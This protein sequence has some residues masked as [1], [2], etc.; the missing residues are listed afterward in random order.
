MQGHLVGAEALLR[1]R[2]PENGM[3]SPLDFIPLAEQLGL[4]DR[5]QDI[6]LRESCKF[7]KTLQ[8]ANSVDAGFSV[9][10]NISAIQFRSPNFESGIVETVAEFDLKPEHIK[11]EITES[12]LIDNVDQTIK[13]MQRLNEKGFRFSIDDFGT[14]YSS[15]AYLHS[16][17]VNELKIDKSF[18]DKIVTDKTG[19]HI[20]DAIISLSKHLQFNIIAEGVESLE[21][22]EILKNRDIEAIQGYYFA[23][24]MPSDEF[25]KWAW[26]WR[27][28]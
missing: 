11:L 21:Q 22:V 19:L 14:G 13:L 20:V 1:L 25:M 7:L 2:H 8:Q 15:L 9:A 3:I 12:M 17:P 6:V 26:K 24:P 27:Q 28:R 16:L 10:I 4:I 5:L 18:I 23:K